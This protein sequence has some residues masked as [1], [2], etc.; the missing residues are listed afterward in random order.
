MS[1][2]P[3]TSTPDPS[4]VKI[5]IL[6]LRD[7]IDRHRDH[8]NGHETRG[9]VI[10]IDPLLRALGW[11][12]EDPERVV[13]EFVAGKKKPDYVLLDRG[14]PVAVIEAKKLRSKLGNLPA[15]R[16]M[17]LVNQRELKGLSAIAYT[18]GDE[19]H[20]YREANEWEAEELSVSSGES[21]E[22]ATEFCRAIGDIKGPG[23]KKC[24]KARWFALGE[25]ASFPEG[26]TPTA[27]RIDR[28]ESITVEHWYDLL[29]EV[30]R[31]L[32]ETGALKDADVP[33]RTPQG[34]KYLVNTSGTEW[35]GKHFSLPKEVAPGFWVDGLGGVHG[36]PR[37]C[38]RL[39]RA[40]GAD[41]LAVE[42][43]FES[44]GRDLKE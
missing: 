33:L 15:S 30:A 4:D 7:R 19:W 2:K 18:N 21:Y 44:D 38:G 12:T 24:E 41:P 34:K 26:Q 5:T 1:P 23:T 9:R 20:V 10:L 14:Q 16:L 25:Q 13:H 8:I 6:S 11:D 42:V 3:T 39:I 36:I 43:I 37:K 29:V 22:T 31:Y 32:I 40:V 17:G 28:G 35:N 27:L